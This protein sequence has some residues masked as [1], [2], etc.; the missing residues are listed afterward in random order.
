VSF[1]WR[2]R[3][4]GVGRRPFLADQGFPGLPDGDDLATTVHAATD[5][6]YL[7]RVDFEDPAKP[8][9]AGALEE[10]RDL[11]IRPLAL[12]SGDSPS[13]V[14]GWGKTWGLEAHGGLL[15]D[16]K[17]AFVDRWERE[18]KRVLFVGDGLN[19]APVLARATVGVSLGA[20]ASA[21]AIETADVAVLDPSP[22]QIVRL[23]RLG[24]RTRTILY[25]NIGLALG[26]KTVFLVLGGL[27][28]AGLW[29]AVFADVGVALLAVANSLRAAK[30]L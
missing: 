11:G 26:L 15:P 16:G 28:L 14:K 22:R 27:G 10:L 6:G 21:A 4:A 23:I 24:R 2:G 20:R 18:G 12:L 25:Q 19:D 13:V 5:E 9:T 3:R 30:D 17:L 29:E 7:G 1:A 8:A